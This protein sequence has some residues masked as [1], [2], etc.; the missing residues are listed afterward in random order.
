MR[1]LLLLIAIL[2]VGSCQ[3][4]EPKE[5][6][7]TIYWDKYQTLCTCCGGWRVRIGS[8]IYRAFDIPEAYAP[9]DSINVVIRYKDDSGSCGKLTNDLIVITSIRVR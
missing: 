8:T 1:Y 5:K 6:E 7:A 9:R 2:V 3:I 4:I